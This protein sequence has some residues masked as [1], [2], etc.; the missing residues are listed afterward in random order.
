MSSATPQLLSRFAF[1]LS[2]PSPSSYLQVCGDDSVKLWSVAGGCV[3]K[4]FVLPAKAAAS[5]T[6]H[7]ITSLQSKGKKKGQQQRTLIAVGTAA[8]SVV[9][10]DATA[11]ECKWSVRDASASGAVTACAIDAACS[12]V[13]S[14]ATDCRCSPHPSA[15]RCTSNKTR[16]TLYTIVII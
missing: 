7:S 6:A 8:G 3:I 11:G 4:Q 5:V 15:L 1:D 9:L 2:T 14:A 16:R 12:R 10:F 13:F